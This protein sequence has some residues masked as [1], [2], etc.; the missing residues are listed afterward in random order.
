[1][2]SNHQLCNA[3]IESRVVHHLGDKK[4][5][6]KADKKSFRH[7]TESLHSDA[8]VKML[9]VAFG[10]VAQ[11]NQDIGTLDLQTVNWEGQKAK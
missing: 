7:I 8:F 3:K 2:S 10:G 1:M 11:P 6:L 4:F 5:P 9:A